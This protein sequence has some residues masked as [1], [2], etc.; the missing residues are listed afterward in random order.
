MSDHEEVEDPKET[1]DIQNVVSTAIGQLSMYETLY[2]RVRNIADSNR[3]AS[4]RTNPEV[5]TD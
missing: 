4:S 2:G 3:S 5:V 1:L